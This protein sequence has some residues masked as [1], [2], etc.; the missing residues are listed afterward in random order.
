[1]RILNSRSVSRPNIR[2]VDSSP[3]ESASV[4]NVVARERLRRRAKSFSK[5]SKLSTDLATSAEDLGGVDV[6]RETG[7]NADKGDAK[8]KNPVACDGPFEYTFASR[9]LRRDWR[10]GSSN[11]SPAAENRGVGRGLAC[12]SSLSRWLFLRSSWASCTCSRSRNERRE[13]RTRPLDMLRNERRLICVCPSMRMKSKPQ[14]RRRPVLRRKRGESRVPAE[15]LLKEVSQTNHSIPGKWNIPRIG[16]V[17]R[18]PGPPPVGPPVPPPH[19]GPYDTQ[20]PGT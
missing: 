1:M 9:N 13:D 2:A 10:Q 15:V 7:C 19:Q 8:Y 14:V 20:D 18:L 16:E 5:L 6:F 11:V 17:F 12:T 3:R 4:G